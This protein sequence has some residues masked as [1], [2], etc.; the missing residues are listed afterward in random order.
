MTHCILA[1]GCFWCIA[2]PYYELHGVSA[3]H[4]GYSGGNEI[5]PI[6]QDVKNQNTSH[7]ECIRIIYDEEQVSFEEILKIFFEHIDPY[8]D[9]GQFI[10]RGDSYTTAI[11]Y[12][13]EEMYKIAQKVIRDIEKESHKEVKVKLLQESS[14]Y[15][16]EEEHQNYGLKNPEAMEQELIESGRKVK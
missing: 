15:M 13:D 8:D 9:G 2:M 6:Y 3:V 7:K 1:G 12:R 5:N 10:D 4:S 16:A 14:F 11:F